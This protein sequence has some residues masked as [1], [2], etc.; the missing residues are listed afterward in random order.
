MQKK[1]KKKYK[2]K[3]TVWRNIDQKLIKNQKIIKD[4]IYQL[5]NTFILNLCKKSP[6][7]CNHILT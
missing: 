2:D 5:V 4:K 6:K 3:Y 1:I 7:I